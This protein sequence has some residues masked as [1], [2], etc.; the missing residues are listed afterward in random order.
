MGHCQLSALSHVPDSLH[1][2]NNKTRSSTFLSLPWDYASWAAQMYTV[3]PNLH[4]KRAQARGLQE[5]WT[6]T[7][8]CPPSAQTSYRC[9]RSHCCCRLW[10]GSSITQQS[11]SQ[12]QAS[13]ATQLADCLIGGL[14]VPCSNPALPL[15]I[16]WFGNGQFLME[17]KFKLNTR[18]T[19]L[20]VIAVACAYSL[21]TMSIALNSIPLTFANTIIMLAI[22]FVLLDLKDLWQGNQLQ[23]RELHLMLK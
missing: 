16:N 17:L 5:A 14:F 15:F 4:P 6:R 21:A 19:V 22:L 7:D 23:L 18:L 3:V 11:L 1:N 20:C 2:A 9:T 13:A 12:G 10:R 8:P